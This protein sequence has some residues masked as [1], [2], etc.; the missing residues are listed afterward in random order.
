MTRIILLI[1][2]EGCFGCKIAETNIKRAIE[3]QDN[4]Y[5]LKVQDWHNI[6]KDI[7]RNNEIH[8]YPTA[9]FCT[10]SSTGGLNVKGKI[11]GSHSTN[12]YLDFLKRVFG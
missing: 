1:T 9:L 12:D 11:A 10:R 8:D 4:S 2:T 5:T 6:D 7:L 3:K